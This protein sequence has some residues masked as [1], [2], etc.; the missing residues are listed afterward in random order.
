[1]TELGIERQPC[2][3]C[4]VRIRKG[5]QRFNAGCI[6]NPK[7]VNGKCAECLL[8]RKKICEHNGPAPVVPQGWPFHNPVLPPWSPP[9][10]PV[11]QI[12]QPA[13]P[14][15]AQ[16][17]TPVQLRLTPEPTSI[18]SSAS[19]H[20]ASPSPSASSSPPKRYEVPYPSTFS[21]RTL[22]II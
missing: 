7:D 13:P 10:A 22:T 19:L 18:H 11:L 1:M 4:V 15:S 17:A 8:R 2:Q 3:G 6:V 14:P 9:A 12:A 20:E 16:P 5:L 21:D